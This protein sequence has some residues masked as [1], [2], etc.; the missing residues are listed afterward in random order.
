MDLIKKLTGKNPAEY[1]VVAKNLVDNSD[2]ALFE[3]LVKQDSFLFDFIK[4]NVAKRIRLA[5][6]KDNYSNL[7]NFF[8]YYSPS[9]D[10]MMAETL[11]EF[12]GVE[13]LPAVKEIFFHGNEV[14]QAYAL[15]F[16]SLI[17][18]EYIKDLVPHFRHA[19]KSDFEPLSINAI[20]L[21]SILKDEELKQEAINKLNSDDEFEQYDAVKF[22][23]TYKAS[24][25]LDLI[26]NT[27]KKSS[28]SENI[29]A[30]IPY[31]VSI[32]ELLTKDFDS[33]ILVLCNII[34]AIPEI[35]SPS[36]VLDYNIYYILED[37][38]LNKLT[39][40]SAVLLR[41]A[42]DKFAQLTENEEY[43]F[44]CD[45]NTKDEIAALNN[46][47]KYANNSKLESLYYE[48]LYEESSFVFFA[49]DF[50]EDI[51]ELEALLDSKNQTLVLKVLTIL[52]NKQALKEEHKTAALSIISKDE[53][54]EVVKAL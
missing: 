45:K 2:T 24:D 38:Y 39:S 18:E 16:F 51:Q 48:E 13:L 35:I 52:K 17:P 10:S 4:N 21:L 11:Y 37:L 27:M 6:N 23:V 33:A 43:L 3:K 19:A 54:K 9:Y 32:D 50:I 30:E 53:L 40:T 49:I 34:N 26:L 47:L 42:K 7:L 44:D 15:K 41:L 8:D 22:L 31:L 14:R 1:E 5:C 46:L 25:C 36:V 20:E 29:A 28:F 12:G